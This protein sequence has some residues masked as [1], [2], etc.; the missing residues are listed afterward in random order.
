MPCLG[1]GRGIH[2]RS[3]VVNEG[4]ATRFAEKLA[5]M[6][7]DSQGQFVTPSLVFH[8]APSQEQLLCRVATAITFLLAVIEIST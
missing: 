3:E 2:L 1:V 4:L 5:R 8:G 6:R 7:C